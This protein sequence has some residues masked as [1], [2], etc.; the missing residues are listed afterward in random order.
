MN[1][2]RNTVYALALSSIACIASAAAQ[3]NDDE[4]LKLAALEALIA[5]PPERA[6]PIAAKVIQ[7]DNSD[8]L[9]EAAL[10]VLSQIDL[11]AAQAIIIETARSGDGDIQA[12]A[13][14]MIG[15]GGNA[16][17]L[18]QL[19]GLYDDGNEDVRDAVLEAFLI[20]DDEDAVY[21]IAV[22]AANAGNEDD[23]ENAVEILGAMGAHE[24]LRRLRETTGISEPLIEA[25][26]ISGDAVSLRE[27]ALDDSDAELQKAAIEAL[28]I[29]GGD[30]VNTTLV[31]IYRGAASEEIREA[32]LEG[33]LIAGHDEGVLELYRS[34]DDAAEKRELL[35]YLVMMGS[36]DVWDIIDAALEG[37][38]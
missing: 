35:E 24:Q 26:A 10:F 15:I 38:L 17:S 34:S 18:A 33:M 32:A 28:G 14:R 1:T 19:Q 22:S 20:A 12:E 29:V 31:E 36:D 6:Y 11:P 27:L 7:G 30:D 3:S 2:F 23:F 4:A 8:E 9:K 13:I 37:G 25:Y 5:A 16:D 21:N